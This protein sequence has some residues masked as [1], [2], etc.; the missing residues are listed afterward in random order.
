MKQKF[1]ES[2]PDYEQYKNMSCIVIGPSESSKKPSQS[3]KMQKDYYNK[4]K[5]IGKSHILNDTSFEPNIIKILRAL[6]YQ[7]SHEFSNI[8]S[9]VLNQKYKIINKNIYKFC[10]SGFSNNN[11]MMGSIILI[12]DQNRPDFFAQLLE[13]I[14]RKAKSKKDPFDL[15][16]TFT[17][18]YPK[19]FNDLEK[20][21]KL[22]SIHDDE[23]IEN[24]K[25][26]LTRIII[27][28]DIQSTN[29]VAF[30]IF[31]QRILEYN[32]R[33]FPKYNYI[34]IFDV[35]YDP[36][37]LFDKINVSL[38]SKIILFS[39]TNTPSNYLYHEILYN[40]IYKMNTGF[41]IPKSHS[42]K[43]V[44]KSIE[45]HQISIESFKHY[46]NLILFQFFFM[47]QW[48][49]DEYLI[50]MEE[51]DENKIKQSLNIEKNNENNESV[52]KKS[53]KKK[54]ETDIETLID[55]K[56]REIFEKKL[57]EIYT[58]ELKELNETNN[59]LSSDISTEVEKL[60]KNYKDKMNTW[61]IFKKFYELF[62]GF[63]TTYLKDSK[64]HKDSVYYFL[65]KFLQYDSSSNFEEIIK[66]RAKAIN[67]IINK[68]EDAIEPYKKYFYPNYKKTLE[69]IEPLLN[70]KDKEA[71]KT[72]TQDLKTFIEKLDKPKIE[73]IGA[74]SDNFNIWVK[75]LFKIEFFRKIN[76]SD[77][78]QVR[79]NCKRKYAN[80]YHRYLDYKYLIEPPLMNTFLVDLF[81]Y[82]VI[83]KGKKEKALTNFEIK[84]EDFEFKNALR[85]Y[86]KCLMNLS[87]TFKL[88]HFFYDFL[89]EFNINTI[90]D[91]N[92][93]LVEKYKKIFL[94]LC[95]WFNLVGVFQKKKGKKQIFVKN[96]YE[97]VK[98]INNK[99]NHKDNYFIHK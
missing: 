53:K 34:L 41:Y 84:Q 10:V 6:Y 65:Y 30:N 38:L 77:H 4:P 35:A 98:Y 64:D 21:F 36:K 68:L 5:V 94:V 58:P 39:I 42:L 76:E 67:K 28:T 29:H 78:E 73:N 93:E 83:V 72:V 86:F 70:N 95:Y 45:L 12:T 25:D 62:E 59:I 11:G 97:K 32:R 54:S 74:I 52:E 71:L 51:L 40:F 27:A 88:N 91:K 49:D 57:K 17:Y 47:H 96:Y 85:A 37:T 60:L 69:E 90:N 79:E 43:E 3:K 26:Q 81:N 61:K 56:R 23:I 1:E 20:L 15:E 82:A 75:E 44:L 50:F 18:V 24:K 66:K 13:H 63:I 80:V 8:C 31:I 87:S 2:L 9:T 99:D 16:N 22:L 19:N 89:I 46:F 33:E 7:Y 55:N 14:K 92:K 48:N